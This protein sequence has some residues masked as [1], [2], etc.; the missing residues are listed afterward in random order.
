MESPRTRQ[1]REEVLAANERLERGETSLLEVLSELELERANTAATRSDRERRVEAQLRALVEVAAAAAGAHRLEDVLDI[2][3]E[4]ALTAIGAASLSISRW[5]RDAARVRTLINVGQLAPGEERLPRDEWYPLDDFPTLAAVLEQG[6]RLVSAVDD[7]RTDAAMKELMLSLDKESSLSV[8]IVLDGKTWGELWATTATGSP[9]FT[10]R[11]A[12]FLHA[13]ADQVAA[14]IGRAEL[15]QRIEALAYEDPLTGLAN[16]RA[17]EEAL[18]AAFLDEGPGPALLLCDIDDLKDVND[19]HGHEAGDR[20]IGRVARS[21]GAAADAY[22]GALV[23]RIGGD[24]FCVLLPRGSTADG[25]D[26]ASRAAARLRRDGPAARISCGV[27]VRSDRALRP[28]ELLRAADAAQY[29]AKRA[30]R[31]VELAVAADIAG[32]E[33]FQGGRSY[34]RKPGA[35]AAFAAELLELL[36]RMG[37]AGAEERLGALVRRLRESA[38]AA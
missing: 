32:P 27:A 37:G 35:E 12:S 13:I 17:L 19:A 3:A 7:P 34:R 24:E 22:E 18:D 21:L 2:A 20:L 38:E 26:V 23:A 29:R 28:T 25:S 15:F 16:R 9:R 14:A 1:I 30:G 11:D 36:E 5:E 31:L 6:G 10:E 4:R 33:T 8:P